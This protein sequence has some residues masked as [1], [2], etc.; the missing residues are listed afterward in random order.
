MQYVG[1]GLLCERPFLL[2]QLWDGLET[3]GG[4][5]REIECDFKR[6]QEV[7]EV[8]K[9][10]KRRDKRKKISSETTPDS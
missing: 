8:F 3:L 6:F 10:F 7:K 4:V 2:A 9:R 5:K 1:T